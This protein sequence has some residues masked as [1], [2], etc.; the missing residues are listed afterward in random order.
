MHIKR[1]D[2]LFDGIFSR[3][4]AVQHGGTFL[5]ILEPY[6]LRDM[7]GSLPPEIMQALVQHYSSK[8]W[9]QRVE[10]CVLHMDI[11]S[12]DFNQVVKLC[13]EHGLY[14]ALIYL[15][16]RGL[17]D[18]R[19]PIEELLVVVQDN[20]NRDV[21]AL[22]Y[23]MLVYLK[24]CFQGLAFPPGHGD[25]PPSRLWSVKEELLQFL[26]EDSK[27]LTSQVL[28]S[29]K[30]TCGSCP[31]LCYFLWLDTEAT[32]EV[33]KCAFIGDHIK[34]N[35]SLHSLAGNNVETENENDLEIIN[36]L[37]VLV[38]KT[39]DTLISVLDLDSDVIRSFVVDGNLEVWPP[40]PDLVHLLE[41]IAFLVSSRGAT[42]SGRVLKHILEYL[43]S[44]ELETCSP[45]QKTDTYNREKQVLTLLKVVP[46][47]D[48]SVSYMLHH[49]AEAQFYK[50]C[51]LIHTIGGQY[52]AALDSYMMDTDE[53]IYAFAF[54][55]K[56]MLLK[57]GE[58]SSF[59]LAV[60]SRIAELV[61]LSREFT[62]LLII[63]HFSRE[64]QYII[65]E[66]HAHPESL[67][68]FLKTAVDVHLF[69]TLNI[70]DFQAVH[71]SEVPYT[72]MSNTSDEIE[73]Y[74]ERLSIYPKLL[75]QNQIHVTD[76]MAEL[77]LELLCQYERK[78]V[79]KFLETFENYRLEHCLRLCQEYGVTDAAAFLL[80]RVG[81]VGAAL[82]LLMNGL[83]E[84]ADLL[85]AAVENTF[86]EISPNNFTKMERFDEIL[87][88][89]EVVSVHDVLHASIGLCQRNTKRL[90]P[91]ESESLW[92]QLLDSFSEPL[93]RFSGGKDEPEQQTIHMQ[94][95]QKPLM[96][97]QR[98]SYLQLRSN[99]VRRIFTQFIGEIIEG[100]SGYV[101][102]PV[103][104]AKLL[105]ENENQEFGDFKPT[106]LR[107]LGTYG[108]EK[109][110]LDTAKSLIE[111]DTFYT[112]SLLKKG[113]SHAYAPL[114][115]ICCICNC[116]LAKKSSSSGIR[117][118]SCGHATH[119]HCES[120][121]SE[122]SSRD[123]E[124]GCPICL[125]KKNPDVRGKSV[126]VD[127]RLV[128]IS[129]T[130]LQPTQGIH[131]IH[132]EP[133]AAEKPYGFQQMSRFEILSN[134]Q[135][136]QR[137]LQLDTLPRL[138]LA[139]PAI[140]HEKVHKGSGSSTGETSKN[141]VKNDKPN[142]RWQLREP[143]LK[144]LSTRIKSNVIGPEKN[145][146]R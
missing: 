52:V 18:F 53:P 146:M 134:L 13:R 27:T 117:V 97:K 118:F 78:S 38:Q 33:L 140:Y 16:N 74:L 135:K 142:K 114:G 48:W 94:V 70:S 143:K 126:L 58:D 72:G 77:Y 50:A 64:S 4:V 63:D 71:A 127:N 26:L 41:F 90:D 119:L 80:E 129:K 83:K 104:M 101:P 91:E 138:K 65:S 81:D 36:N 40:K 128:D 132:H 79:L 120:G 133:D 8:G 14:G 108:F 73:A 130:S 56:M 125:P 35:N 86:S 24:Y 67:F 116:S 39:T 47:T 7:L 2:I 3:F 92:F 57:N 68:L 9:L 54:I 85:V 60:I 145:K 22:G 20:P 66:L 49:C 10:Q 34:S 69:G 99:T 42:I 59:E 89:N 106:I 43:T 136:P 110:I 123:T 75:Q 103:I 1:T 17:N 102:L 109:R 21:T 82:A 137:P 62:Y 37:H 131:T 139:P 25:L 44:Q 105:S 6:I 5:E 28:K 121:E 144:G 31:N 122:S 12:L 124:V 61:K 141:P 113:A 95:E 19:A 84:K 107:M 32:L 30:S 51:G 46:R 55:N 98:F 93:R 29:F 45:D 100:M 111:E 15:F 87:K 112:M 88:L 115:L 96:L 11:S 23:R 76:E